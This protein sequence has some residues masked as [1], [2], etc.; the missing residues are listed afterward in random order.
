MLSV[1]ASTGGALHSLYERYNDAALRDPRTNPVGYLA[2]DG[3]TGA[4]APFL[5]FRDGAELL[6]FV[7]TTELGLLRLAPLAHAEVLD[8]LG[9]LA[10]RE[11]D[12]DRLALGLT[13]A[14]RGWT[15]FLWVGRF[16]D[17]CRGDGEVPCEVRAEL[18]A[19]GSGSEADAAL[20]PEEIPQL[21][22]LLGM[23]ASGCAAPGGGGSTVGPGGPRTTG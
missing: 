6:R 18:R 23:I 7:G 15:E 1:V 13:A 14:F 11:R 9:A 2:A 16:L 19:L 21:I 4:V 22:G 3:E 5:W 17:L 10:W 12:P 8:D 20:S